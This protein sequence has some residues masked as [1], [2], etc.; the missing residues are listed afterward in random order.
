MLPWPEGTVNIPDIVNDRSLCDT[1]QTIHL[2]VMRALLH[3]STWRRWRRKRGKEVPWLQ[4][5]MLIILL[6]KYVVLLLQILPIS[7]TS[8][9]LFI[10][11]PIV[12]TQRKQLLLS[13][14]WADL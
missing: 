14:D 11:G 9:S 13:L 3:F 7:Q 4:N 10:I 2:G 1:K 8:F 6:E 5:Y 12:F